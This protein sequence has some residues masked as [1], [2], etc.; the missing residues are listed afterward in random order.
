MLPGELERRVSAKKA[1][2]K[3]VP[4]L[5]HAFALA[6]DL[7]DKFVRLPFP[8]EEPRV[9]TVLSGILFQA[10]YRLRAATLLCE[11]ALSHEA[12]IM[13]RS[14]FETKLATRF[15]L[16][17][18]LRT[19]WQNGLPKA[20]PPIPSDRTAVGFRADLY[21]CSET[22]RLDRL[23]DKLAGDP[24][25]NDA[26]T[27]AIVEQPK[28]RMAD[29]EK[30]IGP[31]WIACIRK[32]KTY[33]GMRVS[34]LATYCGSGEYY[35]KVYGHQSSKVHA[36]TALTFLQP[37]DLSVLGDIFVMGI[38]LLG[39]VLDDFNRAFAMNLKGPFEHLVERLQKLMKR[40]N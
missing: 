12:E 1:L 14:L 27:A 33:S 32:S 15:I 24:I 17:P 19:D 22:I 34:E 11:D 29:V 20:F 30:L 18:G 16:L 5:E 40:S 21:S 2:Q 3:H 28:R 23:T 4:V 26:A 6:V 37:A 9:Q 13:L 31:E 10:I 39:E 38:A 36:A 25:L 8:P 7:F 35:L